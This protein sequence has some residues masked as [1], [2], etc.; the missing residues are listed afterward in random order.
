MI[1]QSKTLNSLCK[2]R[3]VGGGGGGKDGIWGGG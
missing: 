1:N 3:N 2:I